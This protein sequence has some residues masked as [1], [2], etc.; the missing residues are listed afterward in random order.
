[1][2]FFSLIS[3]VSLH[4]SLRLKN[5]YL[6]LIAGAAFG[7]A[8]QLH[9]LGLVI[10]LILAAMTL[11]QLSKKLW[12]KFALIQTTGFLIGASP[13]FAFEVRHGFPNTR[14]IFEFVTRGGQTTG[15]RSLNL[16]WLIFE[17]TRFNLESILGSDLAPI[18][19]HLSWIFLALVILGLFVVLKKSTL[20]SPTTLTVFTFWFVGTLGIGFYKG[21]LHYHYF[22]YLF[23]APFLLVA[24]LLSLLKSVRHRLAAGSVALIAAGLLIVRSPSW[25][26]GSQLIDQTQNITL[27]ALALTENQPFNFAL[28]A[29][30]NSDHAYRF[31][32]EIN[33]QPPTPLE[34][35][36]TA[37]LIIICE[38]PPDQC[39]PLGHPLWEIAGFGRAEISAKSTVFPQISLFKLVHHQD[40]QNLI[41]KPAPQG[42]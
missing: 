11:T 33:H 16:L 35:A 22:E 23:P 26:P 29:N 5:L 32:M 20:L 19:P 3:I 42:N 40:S 39:H 28:I 36:V 13:F 21:Q 1:M 27:E 31:F 12:F 37:Q 7:I 8:V 38:L 10:G 17:I 18:T 9:Y 4:Y 2:P 14:T 41:G 24:L 30:G 6:A 34:Q 15:P 25:Q